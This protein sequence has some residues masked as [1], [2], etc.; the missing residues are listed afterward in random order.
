MAFPKIL[1]VAAFLLLLSFWVD[2]CHEANDDDEDEGCSYREALL[3]KLNTSDSNVNGRRSCCSFRSIPIGSRQKIV[4]LVYVDLVAVIVLLLGGALA[5]Y[6]LM[7][8]LKMR[9]VR[10]DRAS[11]EMRKLFYHWHEREMS[12]VYTSLLLVVYYFIG[13]SVPSAFILFV[14]RELP[15]PL[16]IKR[17]E[18]SRTT[19][20]FI[21]DRSAATHGQ[22]WTAATSVQNQV[23]MPISYEIDFL[24]L[25][26]LILV[27]VSLKQ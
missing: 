21:S 10:S 23:V 16:V 14:M 27:I 8:F 13:S 2:L 25:S 20:A 9:K 4:I 26:S 6:G 1:F 15:P 17:Q 18:H 5:C 3:E 12:G 19:L 22:R 11:S 7:L 24:M